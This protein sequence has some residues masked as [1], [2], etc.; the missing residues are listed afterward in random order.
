MPG[1]VAAASGTGDVELSS[2]SEEEE[3]EVEE[4]AEV[5]VGYSRGE[6]IVGMEGEKVVLLR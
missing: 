3:E 6:M 4:E 1:V 5:V 2:I